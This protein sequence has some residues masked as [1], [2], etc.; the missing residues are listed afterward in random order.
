MPQDYKFVNLPSLCSGTLDELVANLNRQSAKALIIVGSHSGDRPAISYIVN[1][2]RKCWLNA[3]VVYG[4]SEFSAACG[5]RDLLHRLAELKTLESLTLWN[6]CIDDVSVSKLSELHQLTSLNLGNNWIGEKGATTLASLSNLTSLELVSNGITN[7]GASSLA[8]LKKLTYLG[9]GANGISDTG[10]ASLTEL[11]QLR[12]LDLW[13]NGIGELGVAEL[14]RLPHLNDLSLWGNQLGD[15]AASS[16]ASLAGIIS[17]DLKYNN[18]GDD[19]ASHLARMC[20]LEFLDLEGN[21]I[22]DAGAASLA[23][24]TNLNYLS[25]RRNKIGDE[26]V[27]SLGKLTQLRSLDL[28][29][30]YIN[31]IEPLTELSNL[32]SLRIAE[33]NLLTYHSPEIVSKGDGGLLRYLQQAKLQGLDHLYEAKVLILG[34]GGAGKTSLLRRLFCKEM[35]L[36]TEDESTKGIDIHQHKFTGSQGYPF[37]LNVWDFGGQ[38]IYHATHQFF[39]TKRSLYILVDDTRNDSKNVHDDG[40]KYWLEVIE[41]LSDRCPVIIFQNEKSNRSKLID[42]AGIKGRFPNVIGIYRGNLSHSNAAYTLEQAIRLKVQELPHVGDPIPAQWVKVRLMLEEIKQDKAYISQAEYLEIYSKYLKEDHAEAL[43]L[44]EYFHDLGVYLHYQDHPLLSRT[45]FLQNSWVTEAVF[46]VLDDEATKARNGYFSLFDCHQIWADQIYS[47]MHLELLTIMEKFE[48]CYK[49]PGWKTNTW[50]APQLLPPSTPEHFQAWSQ[51]N[52]LVRTYEY[53]FL[54]KGM[55]SR[56]MVRMHRF[57]CDPNLSWTSGAFF[58]Q[59][60]TKL[61][62][63]ISSDSG[64]A[65]ELRARGPDHKRLLNVIAS[66]LDELNAT[67][68]GLRGKVRILVPCMCKQCQASIN[69]HRFNISMLDRAKASGVES[70]QCGNS[71]QYVDVL[72]LMDGLSYESLPI[73]K[74]KATFSDFD[75]P[76]LQERTIRIF[77][78]SSSEL[79]D[80]RDNLELY[81]LQISDHFR[82]HNNVCLDVVRWENFLD[83]MSYTRMQDEYN[84]EVR[85]SD[86]FLSMFKTKTGRCTEEEFDAAHRVFKASGKPLIYT[87]FMKTDVSND[88]EMRDALNSLWDF[89]EKLKRLGHYYTQFSSIE[90][91]KVQFR[92]QLD[93][94]INDSK[95]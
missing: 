12:S 54:P 84:K 51:P 45:L 70:V 66:D 91:L 17:L 64:R 47:D 37:C 6:L 93:L 55:I 7:V 5:N 81:L 29:H 89:Q 10:V 22:G 79:K 78:A 49:V 24:L 14:L 85:R 67:F 74:S 50:L 20:L 48:L 62:A 28:A 52:D 19:C 73:S 71:F 68:L 76:A 65:I 59:G 9:L 94:L 27:V 69:P 18:F 3:P 15:E 41:V 56:L 72:L 95:L 63:Q 11:K 57:V 31:N 23:S 43:K 42:E 32:T 26:G 53:D 80:D 77:L 86:I 39:L 61:L 83:A 88:I 58:E 13:G 87:Y 2:W 33:G 8:A 92:N 1:R 82:R 46:K 90:D 44:S 30:N 25:L 21:N 40:F 16:I 34:E 4:V 75:R 60:S 38:Q 36:P 35:D